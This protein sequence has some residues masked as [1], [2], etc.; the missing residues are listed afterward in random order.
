MSLV[1]EFKEFALKGNV[2]DL[3]IGIIIGVEFGNV[4]NSMVN[5][6]I[7]PP[8]GYIINGVDFKDLMIVIREGDPVAKTAPVAIRYGKFLQAIFNFLIIAMSV[9]IM[10]KGLNR[11][12]RKPAKA[13]EVI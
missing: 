4:V 10:V 6:V 13:E 7:M 9:F 3:A 8:L 5:D 2:I 1:S 12:N 11:L